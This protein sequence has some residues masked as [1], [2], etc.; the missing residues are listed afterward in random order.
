MSKSRFLMELRGHHVFCALRCSF[1]LRIAVYTYISQR[2]MPQQVQPVPGYYAIA[3]WPA[4]I[5][6]RLYVQTPSNISCGVLRI[7][8]CIECPVMVAFSGK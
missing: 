1:T 5:S 3:H 7:M 4:P 6:Q 8:T 2:D